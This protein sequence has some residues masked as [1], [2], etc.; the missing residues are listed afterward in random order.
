M[1]GRFPGPVTWIAPADAGE[2]AELL[3][4]EPAAGALVTGA[5]PPTGHAPVPDAGPDRPVLSTHRLSETVAD[6]P[7]DLLLTVGSGVRVPDLRR[8]LARTDRW[9]PPA[10]FPPPGPGTGSCGGLVAAAPPAP[11]DAAYGALGRHLLAAVTV[12]RDGRRLR[13]GR[14]VVKNVAGYDLPRL[15]AG[16]RGRLGVL[17]EVTFR[18]WPVPERVRRYGLRGGGVEPEAG[19]E[20]LDALATLPASA[21][22]APDALLWDG[23]GGRGPAGRAG[24][25]GSAPGRVWLL[26]SPASVAARE[27]RLLGWAGERGLRGRREVDGRFDPSAAALPGRPADAGDGRAPEDDGPPAR[28][29]DEVVIHVTVPR[30][31][32]AAAVAGM[33]RASG[34]RPVRLAADP[35]SGVIRCAYRRPPGEEERVSALAAEAGADA[36]IAVARGGEAEHRAAEARRPE[37][38]RALEARVVVALGGGDR[39]WL[40]DYV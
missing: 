5:P 30:P 17:A 1:P 39:S 11:T 14:G 10:T 6:E 19:L 23:G 25:G 22:F 8:R 35:A 33:R 15:W 9:L 12:S 40:S 18:T 24:D 28:P 37:A 16:S 3:G 34:P 4:R 27:R 26:G 36:R 20:V 21:S 2:I 13:W 38:V 29:L 31:R 32:L 7:D